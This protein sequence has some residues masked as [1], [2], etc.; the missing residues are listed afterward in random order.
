MQHIGGSAG[1]GM[2]GQLSRERLRKPW[3]EGGM[4]STL[5][6]SHTLSFGWMK[7][8]DGGRRIEEDTNQVC[9][10]TNNRSKSSS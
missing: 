3:F 7:G 1:R 4:T 10:D 2:R 8:T 6:S 9:Y 5:L